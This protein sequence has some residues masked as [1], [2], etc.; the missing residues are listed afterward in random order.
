LKPQFHR[1]RPLFAELG[2]GSWY[3]SYGLRILFIFFNHKNNGKMDVNQVKTA[4]ILDIIFDGKNKAYGAYDLRNTYPERI[5]RAMGLGIFLVLGTLLVPLF[6]GDKFVD[7]GYIV[8]KGHT[9]TDVNPE[10]KPK[11][12]EKV[13]PP[14]PPVVEKVTPPSP[15]KE[16]IKFV[17]MVVVEDDNV[18]KEPPKIADLEGKDPSTESIKPTNPAVGQRD[19]VQQENALPTAPAPRVIIEEKPKVADIEP[20]KPEIAVVFAEQMP[21]FPGG[22]KQ[23]YKWLSEQIIYPTIARENG[24]MGKVII[25]FVVEKDGT[26]SG[27]KVARGIHESLDNEAV[28]VAKLMPEWLPGKQNGRAVRVSYNIPIIFQLN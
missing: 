2:L 19:I 7:D 20:P 10:L 8:D 25:S 24:I 1:L 28:R 27:I 12:P 23:L 26:V 15:P 21:Q 22:D 16:T 3:F 11:M 18:V 9:F 6:A 5:K 13:I 14:T 17:E 4:P